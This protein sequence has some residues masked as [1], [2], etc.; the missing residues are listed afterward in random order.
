MINEYLKQNRSVIQ[1]AQ[2]FN[3]DQ[4]ERHSI[5]PQGVGWNGEESQSIRYEQLLRILPSAP[6]TGITIN[7]VGCGYGFLWHML[8]DNN[9]IVK[10]R[11]YDISDNALVAS[12]RAQMS[13]ADDRVEFHHLSDIEIADYSVASGIFG[14]RF[15]FEPT[16][17]H[18][19]ILDTLDVLDQYSRHGFAFNMLT[20]YSDPDKLKNDL[21]YADPCLYFD[22]CK[23]KYARNVALL[24]DY[25]LYDFTLLVRKT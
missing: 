14:M 16:E 11:G 10:Y 18:A 6:D 17:W 20:S 9:N 12:A 19:Y 5:S 23:R 3:N 4:L 7:D 1:R 8:S 21:Y 25:G 13:A 22:I 2:T 15:D 24:H